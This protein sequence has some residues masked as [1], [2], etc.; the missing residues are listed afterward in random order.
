VRA[1]E[2]KLTALCRR[3]A[4]QLLAAFFVLFAFADVSVMQAYSGNETVGILTFARQLQIE[5]LK[6]KKTGAPVVALAATNLSGSPSEQLPPDPHS[7]EENCFGCC[8]H[9]L[10]GFSLAE[11]IER[12]VLPTKITA[13]NF[14]DRE[15]P[16][17]DSHLQQLY[18]PPKSA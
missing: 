11:S 14:S 2:I 7:S 1:T 15:R 6:S 8:S 13:S 9:V 4:T 18:Q 12:E 16:Q 3:R 5:K 10:L 17:S